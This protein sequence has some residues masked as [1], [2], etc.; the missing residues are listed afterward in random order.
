MEEP[1]QAVNVPFVDHQQLDYGGKKNQAEQA[2][3]LIEREFGNVDQLLIEKN[4]VQLRGETLI[5]LED[6]LHQSGSSS[7]HT[8]VLDGES[9]YSA[10]FTV[11]RMENGDGLRIAVQTSLDVSQ[12]LALSLLITDLKKITANEYEIDLSFCP[13]MSIT[14]VGIL[15][16][17]QKNLDADPTDITLKNCN[18][19]ILQLLRWAGMEEYFQLQ[20]KG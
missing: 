14:G 4:K 3:Q 5:E 16:M 18:D 19:F 6:E 7:A 8:E 20:G 10:S 13:D 2:D 15:L 11:R 17:I 12:R 1:D 9:E